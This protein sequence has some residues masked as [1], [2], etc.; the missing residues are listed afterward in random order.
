[1]ESRDSATLHGVDAG[2]GK[3]DLFP[4]LRAEGLH[5]LRRKLTLAADIVLDIESGAV[6]IASRADGRPA[7][8]LWD[9]VFEHAVL[10]AEAAL[11]DLSQEARGRGLAAQESIEPAPVDVR[12]P[13]PEVVADEAA[14]GDLRPEEGAEFGGERGLDARDSA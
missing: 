3:A 10:I 11:F 9:M 7:S 2:G 6:A 13:A 5:D 12:D 14:G 8:V 4:F 1:M